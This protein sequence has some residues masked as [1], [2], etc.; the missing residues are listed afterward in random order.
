MTTPN[1]IVETQGLLKKSGQVTLNASGNGVITFDP[2]NSNQRWEIN[3]VV[4][5]TNQPATSTVIPIA[6]IA[7]NTVTLNTMS[8]GN[9]RGAT[10]S[11]N[12]DTF[13]GKLDIG[14]CDFFSVIFSPPQGQSGTPLS[15]VIAT[16]VVTG[17]K[18]T[19][20]S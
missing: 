16:A 3:S 17:T 7:I 20:R 8:P 4:V 19:R 13:S 6:T 12:N 14:G 9:Q 10:W 11:G 15:G 2:D 18:Y 1:G 5:T